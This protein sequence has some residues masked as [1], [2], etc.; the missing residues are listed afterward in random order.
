MARPH[1]RPLLVT[2]R[3]KTLVVQWKG[4]FPRKL[5]SNSL[6]SYVGD[7]FRIVHAKLVNL[8][9]LFGN[10]FGYRIIAINK[11]KRT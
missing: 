2:N 10:E 6:H 7:F 5:R 4:L 11:A 9:H 3:A 8:D 1:E